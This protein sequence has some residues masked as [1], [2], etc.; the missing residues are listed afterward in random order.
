MPASGHTAAPLR[1]LKGSQLGQLDAGQLLTGCG[2][3]GQ[4]VVTSRLA[5]MRHDVEEG[6]RENDSVGKRQVGKDDLPD[7]AGRRA[8]ETPDPGPFEFLGI[9][10]EEGVALTRER[11]ALD[12]G[13][14]GDGERIFARVQIEVI[15]VASEFGDSQGSCRQCVA[16]EQ[17]RY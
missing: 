3:E 6:I 10:A 17:D 13:I 8:L 11:A 7:D 2:I 12:R 1:R 9:C 14:Q 5:H 15:E 16:G 4:Q